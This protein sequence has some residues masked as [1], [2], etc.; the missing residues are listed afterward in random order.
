M[1]YKQLA[2]EFCYWGVG[3]KAIKAALD[4]E[5]FNH[6]WAMHKPPISK[7][8]R[9]LRLKYAK[10]HRG[11]T[12]HEWCKFL[13]SGETW[14]KDGRHRKT[15]VLRRAKKEWDDNCVEEKVQKKKG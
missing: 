9:T 3:E 14:V 6:R 5:V 13:W 2:D 8:N 11:W 10:E 7:K 12:Y 15:R 4:K 1:S